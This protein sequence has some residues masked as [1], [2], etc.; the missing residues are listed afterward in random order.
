M[1][2]L[3]KYNN[4][5]KKIFLVAEDELE[6]LKYQNNEVWDSVGH[7]ELIAELEEAFQ[8]EMNPDDMIDFVSYQVGKE[9]LSKYGIVI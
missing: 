1:T 9:L 7:M 3:E 2:N 5:F 8:I 4:A 6:D